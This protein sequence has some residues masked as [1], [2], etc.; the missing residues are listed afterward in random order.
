MKRFKLI[1]IIALAVCVTI[2]VAA[3]ITVRVAFPPAKIAEIVRTQGT[4]I[5]GREVGVGAVSV[6]VFPRLKL[7]VRDVSL[8]NDTGF[9]ADPTL[10]LKSLD[11]SISWLSLLR[12]A[13]TIY[14]IRLVQPDILFEVDSTG[15]NNLQS[16]GSQD[17][18]LEDTA[19]AL[20][21]LPASVSLESFVIE[22]GRVRYRDLQSGQEVTLGRIDQHASLSLDPKLTD[23]RTAGLLTLSEI[24]VSDKASGLR[25]GGVKVSVKHDV[26][27]DLPGD[28]VRI[29]GIDLAFQDINVRVIGSLK[30]FS[31][32]TP[33]ADIHVSAPQI[34]LSSLFAEIP[35]EIS[36]ELGKLSVAGTASFDLR[37][38]GVLDTNPAKAIQAVSADIGVREGKFGHK[39]VPQGVDHFKVDLAVRGDV[40]NLKELSF[41][42]GPNPFLVQAI[43]TGLLDPIPML[44]TLSVEGELDFGNLMALAHKME[45]IDPSITLKGRQTLTLKA[46]GPLDAANPQRLTASGRAEFI[47]VHAKVPDLPEVRF[48]GTAA[49]TNE[50]IRNQLSIK[51]GKSDAKVAVLVRNYLSL[52]LPA[53]ADGP[54]FA[55][56]H[57]GV[58]V[59]SN[60]IDLD[61]LL[62]KTG[63]DAPD[64]SAPL[65]A[66][67]AWP[68][69]DADISVSLAR[70]RLMNLD[71][72]GFTLKTV[73]RKQS[74][75]TDLK[76]TL[77][78]GSFSSLVA[79]TPKDSLN[80]GF[81][82]KL[83]VNKVEANDFISRLNDRVP[84]QNK[85]LKSLAG[86]DSALFGKFSMNLD[87]RT[88]GLPAAF[89]NNLSG[90]IVFSITDGR[91]V[92]VEWT[93]SL[94]ASL[95][96][97]H[98][99]LGFEQL[100]F[101][102][103]KGD[104]LAENGKLLVRDLSFD[105]PRA[106]AGR[107]S[108]AIGFDNS[109]KLQLTQALPPSASALVGGVG[110]ALL[111]QLQKFAPGVAGGS[112]FPTDKQGRALLYF[113]VDGTVSSP[114][115]SLDA[116]RM[117][118]EGAAG[119]AA[120]TARAA[121]A[122]RA[123]EEKAKLE[124]A[125][126][127]RI[128]AEKKALQEKAAAE[129]QKLKDKA[130]AEAKK[131][132]R[133]VLEGLRK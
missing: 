60:L 41:R 93:K 50:S 74:A 98:S 128:E 126:R 110:N 61:E 49:I 92:G 97:A 73:V 104:L 64:T 123:A 40:V 132:G 43:V 15:R 26:Q 127:A 45:L 96:K 111:G 119:A 122:A 112:L 109:L 59:K 129:G 7:G 75:I 63:S 54:A 35:T 77:Y 25:K 68:P 66:Y 11:L 107:A 4:A 39:D 67:P 12:F 133:K 102:E 130:A 44:K 78:S 114:K 48:H 58:D 125:A 113:N 71:M 103:L 87:L 88:N 90:P 91:I 32:P 9:S 89:A 86:T 82:F 101:S 100:T 116:K 13:P 19:S 70:T 16:L 29:N 8:A 6:S 24:S 23:I 17:S 52:V 84:L 120:S 18:T 121:L 131:Q 38:K 72:T 5:L 36:P 33:L 106:G 105:S 62:P 46:S 22:D 81:G 115:F 85:M 31:T 99:S 3:Y 53:Q 65:T 79:I 37:V 47:G 118:S 57:V 51:F 124:A 80:W 42:T 56:T 55:R 30:A 94:S 108:G 83:N 34:S 21:E 28:S 2:A 27:V 69:I 20:P 76:G 1:S 14:E 95:A 10:S 117:A